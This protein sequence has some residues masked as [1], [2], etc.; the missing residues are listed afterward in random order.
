V[1]APRGDATLGTLCCGPRCNPR[2]RI[3]RPYTPHKPRRSTKAATCRL[4]TV[5]CSHPG[6]KDSPGLGRLPEVPPSS[7]A[8]HNTDRLRVVP[9]LFKPPHFEAGGGFQHGGSLGP[10]RGGGSGSPP[11][12]PWFAAG[13]FVAA[14]HVSQ[15]TGSR[16]SLL[17]RALGECDIGRAS[18]AVVGFGTRDGPSGFKAV[19]FA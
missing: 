10:A 12:A 8:P 17:T 7:G 15:R 16:G 11:Q 13:S 2:Q 5:V 18:V 3:S 6:A 4:A 19:A 14:V 9:H 1:P